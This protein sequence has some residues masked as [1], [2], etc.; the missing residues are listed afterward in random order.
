MK[1][2]L[3]I[4]LLILVSSC[5]YSS[6]YKNQEKANFLVKIIKYEWWFQINNFI[7]NDLK[8]LSDINSNKIYKVNIDSDFKKII[9]AKNASGIA[10]DYKLEMEVKFRIISN[11]NKEVTFSENFKI[12]HN[13]EKFEQS[14]YEKEIKKNFSKMITNKLSLYLKNWMIIKSLR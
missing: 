6:V 11:K 5:G 3:T 13:N 1:K 4:T 9:I 10:T 8:V 7:K 14:N 2:F 12:K